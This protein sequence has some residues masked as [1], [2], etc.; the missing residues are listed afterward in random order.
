MRDHIRSVT[1]RAAA[2]WRRFSLVPDAL[3]WL[4]ALCL[5]PLASHAQDI[6]SKAQLIRPSAVTATGPRTSP[7][8]PPTKDLFLTDAGPGL[9]TGCTYNS[10]PLN[11]LTIDIMVDR[12]VGDVDAN[13]YLV[14]PTPFIS[15][16]IIP[17]SVEILLPAYDIDYNGPAPPE[18]DELLFNGQSL[19]L[20][21]GD[22]NIWKLNSFR[23]DIRSIK[24]PARPALGAAPTP[25]ANRVQIRIDTLSTDRW[26]MSVDWVALLLPI[27]P[28]LALQLD[29]V[30][31]N[32]VSSNAGLAITR[33]YEQRF[34]A[35]C[36]VAE[37][38]GPIAQ[39]PFSGPARKGTG[40]L[41]G[42]A[43]LKAS[44]KACPAGSLASPEV[45][46]DWEVAGTSQRG[47]TSWTGT[48]GVVELTMPPAVGSYDAKLKFSLDNGQSVSVDRRLFVTHKPPT[49][50]SPR[51]NWYEKG[52]AWASGQTTETD[53]VAKVLSGLYGYG[54]AQWLYGYFP[55]KCSW[56]QLMA[57]PLTCNYADCYVFSDVLS[58]IS[59]VLGVG[60]LTPVRVAGSSG[61]GFLTTG[62]PSID[63]KFRGNAR[64]LGG[65]AY[66]KYLF[67]SHSLRKRGSVYYDATFNGQY[68][69]AT[70]FIAANL[71]G[72]AGSDANGAYQ[73]TAEGKRIYSR[74]GN[75]YDSW[76]RNDYAFLTISPYPLLAAAGGAMMLPVAASV[77]DLHFP[78]TA[79]F[80]AVDAD[81]D[82]R[83]DQLMVDVD[84]DVQQAGDYVVTARLESSGGLLISNRP[85]LNS[86]QFTRADFSGSVVGRRIARLF[87]S[88]QQIRAARID[89]PWRVV[90][91]ANG[92]TSAAGS[93]SVVTPAFRAAD[94]GERKVAFDSLFVV[95]LDADGNGKFESLRMTASLDVT[96]AGLYELRTDVSAGGNGLIA[97]TRLQM[98]AAG[99]QTVQLELPALAIARSG[100]DAPYDVA[101]ELYD[102]SGA[103]L[104]STSTRVVGVLASQ[105][106]TPVRLAGPAVEQ[107][108]DSDGNGLFDLLR[109]GLS[110]SAAVVG[111]MAIQARLT[112]ANGASVDISSAARLGPTAS[113]VNLDFPGALLRRLQM[114]SAYSI[115]L[116]FRSP[117]TLQ[118]VDA[119]SVP[120][121]GVYLF[122][123]FDSGEPPR[124]VALT[125]SRSD[126]GIDTNGNGLFERLS[127]T[128]GVTLTQGGAYEWSARLVDRNGVELGFSNARASLAAGQTAISL[129]FDGRAIGVN[130]LDGPFFVRSLL[131]AGPAG[132]NLVSPF[133]GETSAWSASRFEGF[134]SRLPADLN[135]DGVIDAKDLEAFNRALGSSAGDANYNRFADFDRDGRITLN[136][137]RHFRSYYLRR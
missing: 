117:V 59:G 136:D 98:L 115:D 17:A 66:D 1:V 2:V 137:L 27:R 53:V 43:S 49:L 56:D 14:N 38:I 10:S 100:T 25:R 96:S 113:S 72:S 80:K 110:L 15:A 78:G 88:G 95:P 94:F 42:T 97:H 22:N 37:A 35:N 60:G 91:S 105:F 52:T 9:D 133:A 41:S 71:N 120:L 30:A 132:A 112:A 121:R 51:L 73:G 107:L 67:S 109:V 102:A 26:C 6:P 45:V 65:V 118:E 34:D 87:F 16:G 84:V 99:L 48:E 31:A 119:L 74:P 106:D 128:L 125:G 124:T 24:F 5:F 116:S 86:M 101:V 131:V 3:A 33:I 92:M 29:V 82:G 104:D 13:G 93:G 69:T 62:S 103:S 123:K 11:P 134:V 21:T 58:N 85:A 32:P 20:L 77:S 61:L 47:S 111:D 108:I 89:G 55:G 76:G 68:A 81:G 122:S 54:N 12:F 44:L 23:V 18:R 36:N 126:T 57:N 7:F 79:Q 8:T 83:A 114:S 130:G 63:P 40:S 39:Y 70:A 90:I 75:V 19:G 4:L 135:G 127:I 64:P 46:A 129:Q 28:K 50:A